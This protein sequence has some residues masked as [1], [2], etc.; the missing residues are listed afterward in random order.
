M[1]RRRTGRWPLMGRV[2]HVLASEQVV[3]SNFC[4]NGAV[5]ADAP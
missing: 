5:D 4:N 2:A 1:F 3:R